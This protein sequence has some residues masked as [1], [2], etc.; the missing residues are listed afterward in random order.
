MYCRINHS[1]ETCGQREDQTAWRLS[2]QY[3]IYAIAFVVFNVF[4][5]FLDALLSLISD[6]W[7]I[8]DIWL[9]QLGMWW[10]HR[11]DARIWT[12]FKL[13]FADENM[14][15]GMDSSKWNVCWCSWLK[16]KN[17][18]AA[19]VIFHTYTHPS[20]LMGVCF[21]DWPSSMAKMHSKQ[22]ERSVK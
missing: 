13:T 17:T 20:E 18:T 14:P 12:S 10:H 8:S 22:S 4:L 19:V 7:W 15:T 11:N 1:N 3:W 5:A 16:N 21:V 9:F 6:I 2:N